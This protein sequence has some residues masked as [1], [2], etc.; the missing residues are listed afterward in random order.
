MSSQARNYIMS[1]PHIKKKDFAS[2]FIGANP[3]GKTCN[4]VM[5]STQSIVEIMQGNAN[6]AIFGSF[7]NFLKG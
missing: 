3:Q 2:V 1:L 4:N 6:H 5:S 7:F